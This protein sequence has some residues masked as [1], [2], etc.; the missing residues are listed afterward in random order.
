M[1]TTLTLDDDI[2]TRLQTEARRSGRPFKAVVNDCL[3]A[4]LAQRRVMR[5]HEPF[6][7]GVRDLGGPA[8]GASYDNIGELLDEIEG[9]SRR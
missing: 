6:R 3:R 8:Y 4:G 7:I 5:S 2:A 1:R 9:S